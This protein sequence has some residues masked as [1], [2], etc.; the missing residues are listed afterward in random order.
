MNLRYEIIISRFCLSFKL[1]QKPMV[2][3]IMGQIFFIV[4]FVP[5]HIICLWK[6][7]CFKAK[8]HQNLFM[9]PQCAKA[10]ASNIKLCAFKGRPVSKMG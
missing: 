6:I 1:A 7:E 3:V 8:F 10:L 4:H 2:T 9:I 5:L